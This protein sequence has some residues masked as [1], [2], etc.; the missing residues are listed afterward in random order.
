MA[1]SQCNLSRLVESKPL[2]CSRSSRDILGSEANL[3]PHT[4]EW[5]EKAACSDFFEQFAMNMC[6]KFFKTISSSYISPK[7]RP[8]S[9]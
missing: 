7:D 6:F 5:D 4:T 9:R 3:A 2:F 8:E 1:M